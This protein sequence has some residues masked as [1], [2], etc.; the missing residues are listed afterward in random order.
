MLVLLLVSLDVD[1]TVVVVFLDVAAV[2]ALFGHRSLRFVPLTKHF[3]Q[4][5]TNKQE[6]SVCLWHANPSQKI[7]M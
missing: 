4:Q 2:F 5:S 1:A 3:F 6:K 7:Q